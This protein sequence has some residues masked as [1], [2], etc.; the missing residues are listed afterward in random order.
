MN[1]RIALGIVGF[2]LIA[3]LISGL[4]AA[5]ANYVT[6]TPKAGAILP[7]APTHVNV[8]LSE[9]VQPGSASIRVTD[10]TGSRFDVPP[11]T[12]FPD[13]VTISTALNAS[14]PGLYTVTWTAI[15]AVDGHF[16]DGSFS[17][18][19]QDSNGNYSG[20]PPSPATTTG[21]PV[22][23]AEV[24]LRFVGFLGL[25]VALGTIVLCVF[26]WLPAGRDP[27]V[28]V[29]HA[30]GLGFQV[31]LNIARIGAFVFGVAMAGL[32]VLATSLEGA[33]A[34]QGLD[35][36]LYVQS[37][38]LRIAF[39]FFLFLLLS[40]AFALSRTETPDTTRRSLQLSLAV[41]VSA[42]VASSLGTHA[43]ADLN[44]AGLGV[45]ADAAHLAGVALWVGG[46]AG[47]VA[48]RTFLREDDTVTLARIVLGRFSRLAA[49]SVGLVLIGGLVL[50]F[51]LVR[52]W[53]ALLGTAYGWVVLAKIVLFVPMVF[54]GAY[55]RYWLIP[56][57]S[58]SDE[59]AIE[60]V[61]IN[62]MIVGF[63]AGLAGVWLFVAFG[64]ETNWG[65]LGA[66]SLAGGGASIVAGAAVTVFAKSRRPS[67]QS[68]VAV[69]HLASNVR[70]ETAIGIVVL[71]LA[72][73][74]TTMTPVTSVLSEPGVFTLEATKD[75]L[76][77]EFTMQPYP[78]IPQVY[79][80]TFVVT[81]ASDGKPYLALL[82][83]TVRFNLTNSI[84]P[85]KVEN[86]SGPHLGH[87][88]DTSPA[89]SKPGVW[90]IQ[91]RFHR[92]YGFDVWATFY[93]TVRAA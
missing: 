79:T 61:A 28:R 93:V 73:L 34:I 74:L 56:A 25:S 77:I 29:T 63:F 90:Q 60:Q 17:Y 80:F 81:N 92:V 15:S 11:V 65:L 44:L 58:D 43:A 66:F 21:S 3:G 88:Y 19:V 86:L 10:T 70:Y 48:V 8:T 78:S 6:S 1:R 71:A 24:A 75:G 39:A 9:A 52:S 37:V 45:A 2:L 89:L 57:A 7:S 84:D 59:P 40:R 41:G 32:W 18:A 36:S 27:D 72:G 42:V 12:I 49:Y 68:G 47:I 33:S 82:N 26:M 62:A 16:T 87:F 30:F 31:L 13:R 5:H 91:A 50:S 64:P 46:L 4:A 38:A 23:P 51:L 69:R 14:G 22:S 53:D 83:G 76:H 35:N 20:P 55:N 67:A 54:I 85:P